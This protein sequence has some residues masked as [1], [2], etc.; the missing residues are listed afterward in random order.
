MPKIHGING[1]R[2]ELYAQELEEFRDGAV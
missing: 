1:P 2:E